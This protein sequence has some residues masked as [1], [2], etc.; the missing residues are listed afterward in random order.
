MLPNTP[1]PSNCMQDHKELGRKSP[2]SPAIS[3]RIFQDVRLHVE[4]TRQNLSHYLESIFLSIRIPNLFFESREDS[5][6]VD[7]AGNEKDADLFVGFHSFWRPR[8]ESLELVHCRYPA[9]ADDETTAPNLRSFQCH[10]LTADEDADDA[11]LFEN[12]PFGIER[13]AITHLKLSPSNSTVVGS[14][15]TQPISSTSLQLLSTVPETFSAHQNQSNI[16]QIFQGHSKASANL[17]NPRNQTLTFTLIL[18]F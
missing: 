2:P 10:C 6:D 3:R 5:F 4:V 8:L 14:L 17:R 15:Q 1:Q 18:N 9:S 12:F 11:S 16:L 13:I 7:L